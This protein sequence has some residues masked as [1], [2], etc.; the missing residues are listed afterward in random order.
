MAATPDHLRNPLLEMR[1]SS[2]AKGL[3]VINRIKLISL[4]TKNCNI[5]IMDQHMPILGE[6]DGT[7]SYVTDKEEHELENIKG[8][9]C[10]RQNVFS[11]LLRD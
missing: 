11:L 9:F 7:L 6:I 1:I 10:H 3:V 5:H 2:I 4:K 8:F